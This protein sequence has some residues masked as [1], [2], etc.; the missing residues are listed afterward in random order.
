MTFGGNADALW[1]PATESLP[2]HQPGFPVAA[3]WRDIKKV[4]TGIYGLFDSDD[5][6]FSGCGPSVLTDTGATQRKGDDLAKF[7][8]WPLLHWN[9]LFSF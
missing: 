3:H 5:R 4:D 8:E 6:F 2:D 9:N 7:T 1:Q